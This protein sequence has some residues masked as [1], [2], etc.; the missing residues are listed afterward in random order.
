M[1]AGNIDKSAS[2]CQRLT[3]GHTGSD[4]DFSRLTGALK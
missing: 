4:R 1:R 2:E 3:S